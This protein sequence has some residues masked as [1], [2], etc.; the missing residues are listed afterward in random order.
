VSGGEYVL[1]SKRR[2]VYNQIHA[3]S[4]RNYEHSAPKYAIN[5][6]LKYKAVQV[7]C[8]DHLAVTGQDGSY[9]GELL[10]A[11]VYKEH[12]MMRKSSTYGRQSHV[13]SFE[14]EW[15]QGDQLDMLS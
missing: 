3:H 15:G 9:L 8:A 6:I 14:G 13:I 4:S 7:F 12:G 10:L 11:K 2:K 5:G 1:I